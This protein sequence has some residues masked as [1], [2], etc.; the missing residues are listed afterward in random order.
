MKLKLIA[1]KV[2]APVV[3][4]FKRFK[5]KQEVK[6]IETQSELN[7]NFHRSICAALNYEEQK[8]LDKSAEY[9]EEAKSLLKKGADINSTIDNWPGE[10]PL[11]KACSSIAHYG[12]SIRVAEFLLENNADVNFSTSERVNAFVVVCRADKEYTP[13]AQL[14]IKHGVKTDVQLGIEGKDIS[15]LMLVLRKGHINLAKMILE[16]EV[17]VRR[18]WDV[19][20][21]P[22]EIEEQTPV[23][24]ESALFFAAIYNHSEIVGLILEK[25]PLTLFDTNA[26]NESIIHAV[27]RMGRLKVLKVIADKVDK[28]NSEGG[29]P[30]KEKQ[31]DGGFAEIRHPFDFSCEKW[32]RHG[33]TSP[34]ELARENN[35]QPIVEFW[36]QRQST[37]T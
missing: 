24:Q 28:W 22:A 2:A 37:A 3:N 16:R 20:P 34:I 32:T 33:H 11:M 31:E 1:K 29:L 19:Y 6:R 13:L 21:R 25:E 26:Y 8:E 5:R 7:R 30:I 17:D 23:G 4:L 10:T 12:T 36:E 14:L 9:L 18:K 15:T 35:H 27:S